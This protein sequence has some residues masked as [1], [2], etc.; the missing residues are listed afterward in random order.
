MEYARER[1]RRR[2]VVQRALRRMQMREV[3][4]CFSAWQAYA[5]EQRRKNRCETVVRHLLVSTVSQIVSKCAAEWKTIPDQHAATCVRDLAWFTCVASAA[6]TR[7]LDMQDDAEDDV[8]RLVAAGAQVRALETGRCG[9]SGA[10][11]VR[12][13]DGWV[14]VRS[15]T[16]RTLLEVCDGEADVGAAAASSESA[17]GA[18]YTCVASA[19]VTRGLDKTRAGAGAR[20][21]CERS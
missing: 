3:A 7:G 10:E 8:V 19:A 17:A 12:V 9:T 2:T 1:R 20:A 21:R 11:R 4:R 15:R 14:S 18:L 13:A 16:G 5:A 6:V